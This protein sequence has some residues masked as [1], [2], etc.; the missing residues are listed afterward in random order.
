MTVPR[1]AFPLLSVL[2][3]FLTLTPLFLSV[4]SAG[5]AGPDKAVL[6][7]EFI[8]ES[9]PF[10]ACH[11][12]T[13]AETKEGVVAAW[14]GGTQEKHPD[15][16]IW[17]SRQENGKWTV[18]AEAANGVQYSKT[19][20][21][22]VRHPSWNPVLFQAKNGPLLLFYKVGPTP[23]TW[24]G[25]LTRSQD[26]GRT[27]EEPHRLPEGILG[28][29]KNKPVQLPGGDLLCPV[30]HESPEDNSRWTVTF[31]RTPD[32]GRTWSTTGPLNDGI[33]IQA[34]QPSVLF[35]D[36]GGLLAI[37]RTRQNRIFQTASADGGRTWGTMTLGSLPNPNSGTDAVTLKDGRQLIIYNH[38]PGDPG[39]WGG[40]RTPLNLAVSRDGKTWQAALV[41][42]DQP[43]E[44]SYPAIIQTAD[45][46][47]HI[48]YTWKRQRIRHA[49]VDPDKLQPRDFVDGQWP[50]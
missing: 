19:D 16:G 39:E 37:G 1:P 22:V 35:T 26:G 6:S 30:S 48:T 4:R 11:A 43:G 31:E 49:V 40:K 50:K 32:L 27:W 20:G 7:S 21:T 46:K 3:A 45:G 5:A 44:Y 12:S 25:M 10:P 34:I 38:V 14:F 18:P 23:E 36:G 47:V 42:E 8:Y 9:A 2:P 28:P 29:I 15:V 24:W 41:L 13:L 33:A 17:V